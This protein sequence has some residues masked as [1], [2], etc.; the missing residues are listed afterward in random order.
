MKTRQPSIA[1]K[2][3]AASGNVYRHNCEYVAARLVWDT[4]QLALPALRAV[5]ACELAPFQ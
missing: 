2:N 1:W 5:I 4:V 3:M